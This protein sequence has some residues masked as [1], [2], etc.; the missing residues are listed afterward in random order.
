MTPSRRRNARVRR[1]PPTAIEQLEGELATFP[2]SL[3]SSRRNNTFQNFGI[4]IDALEKEEEKEKMDKEEVMDM[5]KAELE[6]GNVE[7]DQ[8]FPPVSSKASEGNMFGIRVM[9]YSD[10]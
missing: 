2:L 9:V 8:L 6:A 7:F 4:S 1:A 3:S 10:R 5:I